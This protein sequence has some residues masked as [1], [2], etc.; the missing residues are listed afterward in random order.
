MAEVP[1]T[2]RLSLGDSAPPFSLQDGSGRTFSL[3]ALPPAKALVVAFVCNHCPFVIHLASHM[4]RVAAR[5][6]ENGVGFVAINSNDVENY[7]ADSPDKMTAFATKHGWDF[8]YL[9]DE[10]QEVAKAYHAA[11][12]PDFFVFDGDRR[13]VYMGQYDDSR[14]GRGTPDGADLTAVLDAIIR[15]RPVPEKRFPSTGC[16]IKW[17]PG[18]APAP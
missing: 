14:P 15:G 18:N 17:K 2:F 13:L 6:W 7:P 5:Y 12:T 11:C 16:N 8:P 10:S 9:Y 4:G 1:S 3:E